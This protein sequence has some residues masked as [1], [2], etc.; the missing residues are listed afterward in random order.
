LKLLTSVADI[1]MANTL[2]NLKINLK[3]NRLLVATILIDM[4]SR[5][6]LVYCHA[7]EKGIQVPV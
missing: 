4:S 2:V 5:F 7:K 1:E 3:K 6:C